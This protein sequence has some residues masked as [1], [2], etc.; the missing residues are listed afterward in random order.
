MELAQWLGRVGLERGAA[1]GMCKMAGGCRVLLQCGSCPARALLPAH[2]GVNKGSASPVSP[3][4]ALGVEV[5]LGS[6][7]QR[8]K[9][10][11]LGRH[12][13]Y[14]RQRQLHCHLRPQ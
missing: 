7:T 1:H 10:M 12:Q 5:I 9:G 6:L 14:A 4:T 13:Y 3:A 2:R 11:G 8:W